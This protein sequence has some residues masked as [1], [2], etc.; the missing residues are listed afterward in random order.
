M[1]RS[2]QHCGKLGFT[3][4]EM[5]VS[6]AMLALIVVLTASAVQLASRSWIDGQAR[7]DN[8]AKARSAL[9]LVARELRASILHPDVSSFESPNGSEGLFFFSRHNATSGPRNLLAVGY[10]LST[11]GQTDVD[12]IGLLRQHQLWTF[13]DRVPVDSMTSAM[14]D[15]ETQQIG[16]GIIHFKAVFEERGGASRETFSMDFSMPQA[17]SNTEAVRMACV[18]VDDRTLTLLADTDQLGLVVNAL[19][20]AEPTT[21]ERDAQAWEN[22]LDELTANGSLAA[23]M[24]QGI[25]IF[26]Q[27]VKLPLPHA[28]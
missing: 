22:A 14:T 13:E 19:R 3:L 28:L 23:V 12:Q 1:Y 16:P 8:F 5:L 25:R 26:E 17:L 15:S 24:R 10:Q 9:D 2:H 4:T 27:T 18:V 20:S 6:V 21:G 11:S 7:A